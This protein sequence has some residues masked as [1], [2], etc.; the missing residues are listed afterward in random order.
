MKPMIYI[1]GAVENSYI[2]AITFELKTQIVALIKTLY[3]YSP[4]Y[5]LNAIEWLKTGLIDAPTRFILDVELEVM[6]IKRNLSRS[7]PSGNDTD[8]DKED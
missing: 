4:Q 2:E 5:G 3:L 1:R 6:S 8:D 7:E